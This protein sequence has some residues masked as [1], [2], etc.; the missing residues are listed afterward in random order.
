MLLSTFK[1]P[2]LCMQSSIFKLLRIVSKSGH[3]NKICLENLSR[4]CRPTRSKNTKCELPTKY[5]ILSREAIKR[6]AIGVVD[7]S[8]HRDRVTDERTRILQ[9]G[10]LLFLDVIPLDNNVRYSSKEMETRSKFVMLKMYCKCHV[11]S[12]A[13]LSW[14]TV[15]QA[16][17]PKL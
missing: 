7:G 1:I 9:F 12:H 2:K 4:T 15:A 6:G 10:R 5:C 17:L 14:H 16:G 3:S 8:F 11:M 13:P